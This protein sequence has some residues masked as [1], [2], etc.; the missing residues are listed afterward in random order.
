MMPGAV[1]G[2]EET[3]LHGAGLLRCIVIAGFQ[4]AAAME[5]ALLRSFAAAIMMRA[6]KIC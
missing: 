6:W 2:G 3:H 5:F 1:Q 4:V